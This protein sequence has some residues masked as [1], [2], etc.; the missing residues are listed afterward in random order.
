MLDLSEYPNIRYD[1][2]DDVYA[3]SDGEYLRMIVDEKTLLMY[4]EKA[5]ELDP[6]PQISTYRWWE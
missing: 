4:M 2:V 1:P 5:K 6:Q 3:V